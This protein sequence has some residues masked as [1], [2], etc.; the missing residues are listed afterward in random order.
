MPLKLDQKQRKMGYNHPF[1]DHQQK[2]FLQLD[3]NKTAIRCLSCQRKN[4]L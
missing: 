1:N 4:A 3:K 2:T